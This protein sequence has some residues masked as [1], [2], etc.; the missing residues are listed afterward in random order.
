MRKIIRRLGT[1]AGHGPPLVVRVGSAVS[2][3]TTASRIVMAPIFVGFDSKC[4]GDPASRRRFVLSVIG[5][6]MHC[7]KGTFSFLDS[8][9]KQLRIFQ[10]VSV[11]CFSEKE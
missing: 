1:S 9:L 4:S 10:N 11:V 6:Q 3:I 7:K 8:V 2:V 5:M